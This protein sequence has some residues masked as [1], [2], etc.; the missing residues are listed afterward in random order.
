LSSPRG[1]SASTSSANTERFDV[2]RRA[3]GHVAFGAGIHLCVGQ[4]LARLEAE[5]IMT[6]AKQSMA[7]LTQ[8]WP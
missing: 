7:S 1:L 3:A 2:N 8:K 6:A 5:V 4:M